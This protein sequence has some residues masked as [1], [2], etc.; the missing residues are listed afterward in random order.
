MPASDFS[1]GT[2]YCTQLGPVGRPDATELNK[3][4]STFIPLIVKLIEDG[5]VVPSEYVVI[6]EPGF[7]SVI[8]AWDYQ[9]KGKGGNKKVMAKLQD[10]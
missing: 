4:I 7:D 10:V 6:G 1:G 5:K 2:P 9:S 8:E 3:E